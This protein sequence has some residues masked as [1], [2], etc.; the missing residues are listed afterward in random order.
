MVSGYTR[1]P[2]GPVAR[3]R[4][5]VES[6]LT[7]ISYAS[8]SLLKRFS[9]TAAAFGRTKGTYKVGTNRTREAR[10]YSHDGP[11]GRRKCGYILATEGFRGVVCTLAVT[12]TGGP[13]KA[14]KVILFVNMFCQLMYIG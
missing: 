10:V 7:D 2:F 14:I 4:V 6:G 9:L 13:G 3:L 11:I 12:C 5:P 1:V 8:K